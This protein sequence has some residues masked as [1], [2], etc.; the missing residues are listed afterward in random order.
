MDLQGLQAPSTNTELNSWEYA[1]GIK[2]PII[3]H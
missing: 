3:M 2:F 1:S